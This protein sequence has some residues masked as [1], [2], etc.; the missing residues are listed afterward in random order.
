MKVFKI[1]QAVPSMINAFS[2]PILCVYILNTNNLTDAIGVQLSINAYLYPLYWLIV[3]II[4]TLTT[5]ASFKEI[6]IY[7]CINIS[8]TA[9]L[10]W[11]GWYI[12]GAVMGD[13]ETELMTFYTVLFI[14]I[15]DAIVVCV[16]ILYAKAIKR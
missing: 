8:T 14:A 5:N 16:G 7:N 12:G 1:L 6:Y 2:I 4:F 3:N 10:H 15:V 13:I 11:I 9:V